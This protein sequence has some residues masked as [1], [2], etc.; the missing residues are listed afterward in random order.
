MENVKPFQLFMTLLLIISAA[1]VL[2]SGCSKKPGP[3][4]ASAQPISVVESMTPS[5]PAKTDLSIPEPVMQRNEF[6]T[7]VLPVREPQSLTLVCRYAQ[8]VPTIDGI[9]DSI[10]NMTDSITTLDATSQRPI[11]LRCLHD[12]QEIFFLARYPDEA[13][14]ESHKSWFWDKSEQIYKPGNDREDMLV[15]KWLME[16]ESMSFSADQAAPHKADIWFWKARRTNQ[17]GYADDKSHLMTVEP[18][19][20]AVAVPSTQYGT[21]YLKRSGDAGKSAYREEMF[22]EYQGDFVPKY[23]PRTP[24]G[25]RADVQARGVWTDGYWTIEMKRKLDTENPDDAAFQRGAEFVFGACLYEMAAMGIER[26]W[27]QPLYRTGNVYDRLT[28]EVE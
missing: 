15:L 28:L 24:E 8:Q 14:S 12:G 7:L 13:A 20:D 18:Q 25:S 26:D 19:E 11:E 3:A 5:E 1:I 27:Y 9:Q 6:T 21:L 4:A 22:F 2:F 23:F 10:W 17:N 16:G